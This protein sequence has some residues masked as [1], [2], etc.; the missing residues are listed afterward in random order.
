MTLSGFV[1]DIVRTKRILRTTTVRKL[2]NAIG[3]SY[4]PVARS[5]AQPTNQFYCTEPCHTHTRSLTNKYVLTD[6]EN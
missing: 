5:L 4:T 6:G 2:C 1:A 3:Q